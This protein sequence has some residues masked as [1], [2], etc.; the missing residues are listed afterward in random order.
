MANVDK[1]GKITWGDSYIDHLNNQD[2]KKRFQE[3]VKIVTINDA[4]VPEYSHRDDAGFDLR[5]NGEEFTLY[6]GK[7]SLVN[8][9]VKVQIPKGFMLAICSRS[10]LSGR[11]GI[12]VHNS[13]GI[14]DSGFLGEIR[15]IL[16]NSTQGDYRVKN[17]E[18]IAQ[19]VL[20]PIHQCKFVK[21]TELG[22]TERGESGFG[23]T[24]RE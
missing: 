8:T 5:N 6:S 18:R 11:H 10:G 15:V 16:F 1:Y 4:K 3:E 21:V 20:M 22:E 2:Y 12:Q 19:G 13:P 14:V 23:S 9:G 7:T 17:G 24:G